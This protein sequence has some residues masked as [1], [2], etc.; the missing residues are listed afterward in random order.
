M[1]GTKRTTPRVIRD[2]RD[3]DDGDDIFPQASVVVVGGVEDVR[4]C[5]VRPTTLCPTLVTAS[6]RSSLSP[7]LHIGRRSPG[8]GPVFDH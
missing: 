2:V 8:A 5:H 1:G 3:C 4:E 7:F 6:R